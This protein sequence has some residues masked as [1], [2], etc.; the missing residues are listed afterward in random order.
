MS[1]TSYRAAPPRDKPCLPRQGA[2][3][4][5]NSADAWGVNRSVWRL[6]EKAT[7]AKALK[8]CE[9]YV[10]TCVRFGKAHEVT[11]D[12]F[13]M[14]KTTESGLGGRLTRGEPALALA[15]VRAAAPEEPAADRF[16]F[17]GGRI[18]STAPPDRPRGPYQKRRWRLQ[19]ANRPRQRFQ[20]PAPQLKPP[21]DSIHG[22]P[23]PR[24]PRHR[25]AFPNGKKLQRR[26]KA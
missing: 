1:L 18:R 20:T 22:I 11:F 24:Q 12:D 25:P 21:L 13:M 6:P 14:A 17:R 15:A 3:T 4:E 16:P 19:S 9:R 10:P 5:T 2:G 26:N 7:R 23:R 8:G